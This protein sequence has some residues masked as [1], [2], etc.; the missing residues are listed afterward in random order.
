MN[1]FI[2]SWILDSLNNEEKKYIISKIYKKLL[3]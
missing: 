1:D 3:Q 2:S